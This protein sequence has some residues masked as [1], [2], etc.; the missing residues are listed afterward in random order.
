MQ[1]LNGKMDFILETLKK[2]GFSIVL[3]CVGLWWFNRQYD[4]LRNEVKILNVV[5]RTELKTALEQNTIE[6]KKF[7]EE[8]SKK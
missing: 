3:L 8:K 2:Q 7:N 4:E 6:L 1:N 5:I